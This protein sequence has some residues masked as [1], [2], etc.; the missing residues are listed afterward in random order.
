MYGKSPSTR[1]GYERRDTQVKILAWLL[2]ALLAATLVVLGLMKS[3]FGYFASQE[4][5]RQPPPLSLAGTRSSVPP[6]PRLQNTPFDELRR[7][8]AEEEAALASYG[9]VDR[10]AGIV[11]IPIEQALDI[12]ARG[13]VTG[14]AA[15]APSEAPSGGTP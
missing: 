4:D 11:R 9:W 10:K 7:M 3:L 1:E 13:G 5:R 8:R 2:A 6:E 15:P 12:A 14:Q